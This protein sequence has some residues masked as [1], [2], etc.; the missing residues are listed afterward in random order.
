MDLV[1]G[2]VVKTHGVRGEVVVE[3]RTDDPATRFAVGARLRG[4]APKGAGETEY[5]VAAARNHSGRLLLSLRG[6][7][8][9]DAAEA[10]RGTQFVI[11][12]SEVDSGDD[13]DEFYDHELEGAEVVTVGGDRVGVLK[14]IL[15]LPGGDVLAVTTTDG[16]EVLVPFVRAIV[17]TVTRERIEIDPPEGLLD[18]D[19]AASERD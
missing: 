15:H 10:L 19:A 8:Y 13:P 11:D 17:P 16:L 14:E 5:V 1:V 4:L 7:A 9:R 3:V 18:P 12:S 2:R 6:V